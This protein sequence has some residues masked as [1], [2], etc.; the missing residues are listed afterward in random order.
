VSVKATPV[1]GFAVSIPI[2]I[3]GAGAAGLCAAL[4]ARE[5][6]ADVL[7]LERDSLPR[8]STALSAGLI[9]AAGTSFQ[10]SVGIED[11]AGR[12]VADIRR[13]ARGEPDLAIVDM[14]A[15]ESGK[16]VE[17]LADRIGLP[18]TLVD[19]FD[20]PGHSV[21]RMHGLPTRSGAELIDHLRAAAERE[22]IPIVVNA[23]VIG[24]FCDA[25]RV[26]RGVEITRPD[27]TH[28]CIGCEA[29]I[30]ACNGYGGAADLVARYIPEM[31]SAHYFGH[32]GNRGDAVLWGQELGAKLLYMP[33][34]QGHGSVAHPHGV[35]ITWAVITAG[36][37]QVNAL[38]QRFADESRGY[39]E[40]AA[41]VLAQPEGKAFDIFDERIA[42]IARQFEDFRQAETM[43][44]V[45]EA[46]TMA[47]L[48]EKLKLSSSA[49]TESFEQVEAL[50]R[51]GGQD[52]FG[53]LF[54]GQ[55]R[56]SP[57][58][59]AVQVTGALFHTQGGL[60][61]DEK[62]RV[63][64]EGGAHFPN[65]FAAGGAA[66]G[67]SGSLASGYL[68]GNGLLTATVLGRIAG[69]SAA[70]LTRQTMHE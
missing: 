52:R 4:S 56:L 30:L 40:Q 8:G 45:I 5:A 27:G 49:L 41:I 64:D 33:G 60:A 70:D 3:V 66:A 16:T 18:F 48:A 68:S 6:G 69:R 37:F 1:A 57:P 13:K 54:A 65:L 55:P 39:S 19:D 12:F 67:I 63:L 38:G 26:I 15:R 61:V 10:Q 59:K 28:H 21:R 31:R 35:L 23:T 51:S 43:G 53:R 32:P 17:W 62:A 34:Y 36:G 24:L 50:K 9:P 11:S 58:F 42:A 44:A 25:Q 2:I 22:A 47:Q 14:I 46:M 20:Y 7:V 29:L